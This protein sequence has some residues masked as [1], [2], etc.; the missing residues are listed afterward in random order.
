[1][2]FFILRNLLFLVTW[3]PKKIPIKK[4][5]T[6]LQKV[7]IDKKRSQVW[8]K[9]DWYF[10][11]YSNLIASSHKK[12]IFAWEILKV[13]FGSERVKEKM[14]NILTTFILS[15]DPPW[16]LSFSPLNPCILD[17]AIKFVKL[18]LI[19]FLILIVLMI[20]ISFDY[21]M[22]TTQLQFI[23]LSLSVLPTK[24]LG[25]FCAP[26][27]LKVVSATFLLVCF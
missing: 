17:L 13:L 23:D 2:Y 15:A 16:S 3:H 27:Y 1:M 24:S 4:I 6:F 21:N 12:L 18:A 7:I 22:K 5:I 11:I 8:S 19:C 26:L 20:L 25:N 14:S 9:M 10:K